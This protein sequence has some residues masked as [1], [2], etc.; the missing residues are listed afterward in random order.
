MTSH[1]NNDEHSSQ[2][3]GSSANTQPQQE[4]HSSM[5]SRT[6]KTTDGREVTVAV[7]TD[8]EMARLAASLVNT[9]WSGTVFQESHNEAPQEPETAKDLW[10]KVS[11]VAQSTAEE[12]GRNNA[13]PAAKATPKKTS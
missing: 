11:G 1:N 3:D 12:A 9:E 13:P 10:N 2:N 6:F 4:D 8:E 7:M 5:I